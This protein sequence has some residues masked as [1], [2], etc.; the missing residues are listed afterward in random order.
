VEALAKEN[1]VTRI[2]TFCVLSSTLAVIALSANG[3]SA[4]T[5]TVHTAVPRV[6]VHVPQPKVTVHTP[7]LK[8]L[9]NHG[10]VVGTKSGSNHGLLKGSSGEIANKK[11]DSSAIQSVGLP[12]IDASDKAASKIS[13]VNPV[14][15]F[16]FNKIDPAGKASVVFVPGARL[17]APV[18]PCYCDTPSDAPAPSF[19]GL[20]GI[21]INSIPGSSTIGGQPF[22]VLVPGSNSFQLGP[23]RTADLRDLGTAVTTLRNKLDSMNDASEM[24]SMRLQMSM[25]Q[26]SK[27]L[28]TLSNMEKADSKTEQQIINNIKQ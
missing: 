13:T 7:Q 20:G 21:N 18:L 5:I 27:L 24:T 2:S 8:I 12:A 10:T 11:I 1:T 14:P 3:V 26:R 17:A 28:Q 4:A 19:V 15:P 9:S 23:S 6:I 16:S 22:V 25:D